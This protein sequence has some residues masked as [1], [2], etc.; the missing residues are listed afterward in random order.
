[1]SELVIKHLAQWPAHSHAH[2]MAAM[3]SISSLHSPPMCK[4]TLH[5]PEGTS[6]PPR[7]PPPHSVHGV[8]VSVI[9]L[10][11][12]HVY[13]KAQL[14]ILSSWRVKYLKEPCELLTHLCSGFSSALAPQS[15]TYPSA[16]A[17]LLP[18]P[19]SSSESQ[20]LLDPCNGSSEHGAGTHSLGCA[21]QPGLLPTQSPRSGF[22]L[23][24]LSFRSQSTRSG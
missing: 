8:C 2:Y 5:V 22:Y 18:C 17:S 1:M 4:I 6:A 9:K 14:Y 13:S 23:V 15:H 24:R 21:G 16:P 11:N 3:I 19:A 10:Q 7:C 20:H 12:I